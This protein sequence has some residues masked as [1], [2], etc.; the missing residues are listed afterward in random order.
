M[1]TILQAR[2]EELIKLHKSLRKAAAA[3]DIDP[4]NLSRMRSGAL[5]NPTQATLIKL[6][7]Y[8]P[9]ETKNVPAES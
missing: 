9:G 4:G 5:T 6:S 2:I 1:A 3:V 7:L 8:Y